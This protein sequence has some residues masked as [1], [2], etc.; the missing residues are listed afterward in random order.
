MMIVPSGVKIHMALGYTDM[1]RGFDG[2]AMLV[3]EHLK[4]DPFSG[5]LFV[6]RGRRADL[7]KILYWDGSGLCLFSKRL[8]QGQFSW[9][10]MQAPGQTVQ[11]TR[12]QLGMLLEGVNWR[13]PERQ[14]RPQRAG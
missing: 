13:M 10:L 6:F 9:P 7:I 14:W 1:R 2:L 11:L 3:Q 8:E 12:T 5:Q 4:L